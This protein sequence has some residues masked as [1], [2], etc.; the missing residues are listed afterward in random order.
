MLLAFSEKQFTVD[1]N[2]NSTQFL[3]IEQDGSQYEKKVGVYVC[4]CVCV[5]T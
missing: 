4:V 2:G 1:T 3:E 5:Y